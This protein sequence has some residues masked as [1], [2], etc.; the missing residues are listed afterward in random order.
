[1]INDFLYSVNSNVTVNYKYDR[2]FYKI[3][4][5]TCIQFE[6][7]CAS[8]FKDQLIS[9]RFFVSSSLP[10][11]KQKQFNLRYH[12]KGQIFSEKDWYYLQAQTDMPF[13]Y[14]KLIIWIFPPFFQVPHCK[15]TGSA[16]SQLLRRTVVW[17]VIS[18]FK[19]KI[20]I[21]H[22]FLSPIKFSEK[23]GPLVD[24]REHHKL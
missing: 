9:K 1:M 17:N 15:H 5:L 2:I 3:D 18:K 4:R 7:Q 14:L 11:N 10:K 23:K 16:D 19:F 13:H 22:I 6:G 8:L 20:V 21:W 12:S 24:E